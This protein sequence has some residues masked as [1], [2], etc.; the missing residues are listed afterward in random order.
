MGPRLAFVFT[1]KPGAN[2]FSYQSYGHRL[3]RLWQVNTFKMQ[4]VTTLLTILAVL[5]PF[6]AAQGRV[7]GAVTFQLHGNATYHPEALVDRIVRGPA[8]KSTLAKG[9]FGAKPASSCTSTYGT[10]SYYTMT[11]RNFLIGAYS[12]QSECCAA[13]ANRADC[14]QWSWGN[15]V[16]VPGVVTCAHWIIGGT[17]FIGSKDTG[18]CTGLT[19]SQAFNRIVYPN[20]KDIVLQDCCKVCAQEPWCAYFFHSQGICYVPSRNAATPQYIFGKA[21]PSPPPSRPPPPPPRR[22][23]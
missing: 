12:T 4:L 10:I 11:G 13:C 9:V 8:E 17:P 22:T 15:H 3:A 1:T 16:E 23:G 20:N 7:Q 6:Q 5:A 19:T 18:S 21:P 14:G 2:T